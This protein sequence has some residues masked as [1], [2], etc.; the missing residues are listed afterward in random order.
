MLTPLVLSASPVCLL[1]P[2]LLSLVRLNGMNA[3]AVLSG[4]LREEATLK[5]LKT[6]Y[7]EELERVE[8]EATLLQRQLAEVQSGSS[9][10]G[11]GDGQK[12]D[13]V[14]QLQEDA[15]NNEQLRMLIEH[16]LAEQS[17]QP[18]RGTSIVRVPSL[19]LHDTPDAAALTT[20]SSTGGRIEQSNQQPAST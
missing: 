13:F 11:G 6:A 9:R 16:D 18:L 19:H 2:S 14:H 12:S 10:I 20:T 5:Q 1:L 15:Q 17:A 7:M 8:L 4:L 3:T